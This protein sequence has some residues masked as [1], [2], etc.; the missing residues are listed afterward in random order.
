MVLYFGQH[1]ASGKPISYGSKFWCGG[2]STAYLSWLYLY[3]GASTL[4]EKYSDK[5]LDYG[6]VMT[7]M[8]QLKQLAYSL[9]LYLIV[10]LA[11]KIFREA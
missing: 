4:P 10:I 8:D 11:S 5:G 6:V 1:S 2:T 3:Q 9:P 7:C